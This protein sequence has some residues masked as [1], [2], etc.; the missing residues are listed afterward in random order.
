MITLGMHQISAT[1]G[2]ASE[3]SQLRPNFHPDFS[4]LSN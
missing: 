3:H 1:P 2:P 4:I